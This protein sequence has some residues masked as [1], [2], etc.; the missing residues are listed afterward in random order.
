MSRK[1]TPS[2]LKLAKQLRKKHGNGKRLYLNG[3]EIPKGQTEDGFV[4]EIVDEDDGI[5]EILED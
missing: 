4:I 2:E 5:I 1:L 3:Y